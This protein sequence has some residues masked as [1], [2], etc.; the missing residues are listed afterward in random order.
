MIH[1]WNAL[2][3]PQGAGVH[4]PEKLDHDG[5][6]HG[7]GGVKAFVGTEIEAIAGL[8]VVERHS[9][10]RAGNLRDSAFDVRGEGFRLRNRGRREPDECERARDCCR[11]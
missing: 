9:D 4:L 1:Q 6:F 10:D 2:I 5:H 11:Y 3:E 7:A 8:E